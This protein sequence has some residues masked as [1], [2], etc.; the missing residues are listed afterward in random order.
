MERKEEIA[1]FA[2]GNEQGNQI[3]GAGRNVSDYV[4]NTTRIVD[5][6]KKDEPIAEYLEH[7]DYRMSMIHN[8]FYGESLNRIN[9]KALKKDISK[10]GEEKVFNGLKRIMRE[11]LKNE[12]GYASGDSTLQDLL[13]KY[14]RNKIKYGRYISNKSNDYKIYIP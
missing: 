14:N 13:V 4:R 10:Y 11:Y 9:K 1:M 2:K 8:L 3:R 12:H 6:I 7:D 5:L